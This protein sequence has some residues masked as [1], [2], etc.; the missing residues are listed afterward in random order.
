MIRLFFAVLLCLGI[1]LNA[2][3]EMPKITGKPVI[4]T[5]K[6]LDWPTDQ[7]IVSPNLNDPTSNTLNDLHANIGS[8][9]LVLS[10][11]GNYHPAL[12]DVWP[13]FLAKFKD[14]P[15]QNWFYTTSP[16]IVVPQ[17]KNGIAQ[18][19]NFYSTC[20]PSVAVAS[21]KV[22]DKLVA[23]GEVDGQPYPLYKDRG[24]VI[25][26]KAGN[27]KHIKTVWDLARKNVTIVTPNPELEPGAFN[28]YAEAIYNIAANDPHPPKGMT[29]EKLINILFN[30]A[31]HNKN[32]WM[33]GARIHHR[34]VPWSVVYG[35]ADAGVIL[36]HLGLYMSQTFPDKLAIIPLGG[37][38]ADPQPLPGTKVGTRFMAK[39]K[40]NWTPRQ[41]EA[42]EML[43]DTLLSDD[44]TQA[45]IKRGLAR[46]DG[47][48]PAVASAK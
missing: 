5:P 28:N 19:G 32:K 3:A 48:T 38:V 42:R 20:K 44:F 1:S 37:T 35:K 7:G 43:V 47:F 41:L 21:K 10:T 8:C 29:A 27:P 18:F 9:D 22:I 34:D 11:E 25:L 39:L 2:S 30:G 17:V 45:L 23:A 6:L 40:G 33:G 16:P 31:S 26:V 24:E 36:Y 4:D 46:P 15:L 14:K 13:V 12:H